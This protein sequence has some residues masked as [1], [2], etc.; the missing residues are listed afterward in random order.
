MQKIENHLKNC[1]IL[2]HKKGEAFFQE[3]QRA[4]FFGFVLSGAYKLTMNDAYGEETI[5]HFAVRG[6]AL[7][8]MATMIPGCLFPFDCLSMSD[9]QILAI[10]RSNF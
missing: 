9:S 5:L 7:G 3:G 10:P 2:N 1:Q 4:D 6:E 8:I